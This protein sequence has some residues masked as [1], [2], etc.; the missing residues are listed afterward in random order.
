MVWFERKESQQ[1]HS[2]KQKCLVVFPTNMLMRKAFSVSIISF[3]HVI[4]GWVDMYVQF[5]AK[6][7]FIQPDT[8]QGVR[9]VSSVK[10]FNFEYAVYQGCKWCF[11]CEARNC[12]TKTV[13]LQRKN[14]ANINLFKFNNRNTRKRCE[15][16]SKLAIKTPELREWTYF[17]LN[18]FH[19]FF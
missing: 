8:Y 13:L 9:I 15:I 3:E 2:K 18:I 17:I 16:C 19:T 12:W 11:A 5:F 1:G 4:A 14:P 6:L 10:G 7:T